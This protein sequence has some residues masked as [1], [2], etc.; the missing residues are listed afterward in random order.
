MNKDYLIAVVD[1]DENIRNLIEAYLH[2]ENYRTVGLANAEEAWTL[3]RTNPRVCGLWIL[4][5]LEWTGMNCVDVSEMKRRY[6]LL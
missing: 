3:W 5:Y 4:C 2:K 6:R 1:D